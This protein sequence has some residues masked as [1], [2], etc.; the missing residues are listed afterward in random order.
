M[1]GKIKYSLKRNQN[2]KSNYIVLIGM[3]SIFLLV[4]GFSF[5]L[6]TSTVES[7]GALNIVEN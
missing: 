3:L 4:G 7:S 2:V 6:F 1:L 5:A